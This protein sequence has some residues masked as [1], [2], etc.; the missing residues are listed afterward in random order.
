MHLHIFFISRQHTEPSRAA[1]HKKR[2]ACQRRHC[3]ARAALFA[4]AHLLSIH[5]ACCTAARLRHARCD[6]LSV[7]VLRYRSERS[8]RHLQQVLKRSLA[9]TRVSYSFKTGS[10]ISG[11][12]AGLHV[13]IH[14][15]T[16]QQTK[17][18]ANVLLHFILLNFS[19][20]QVISVVFFY[21]LQR[22]GERRAC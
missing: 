5:L 22:G 20:I 9:L 18:L 1:C 14:V 19:P 12:A 4:K 15:T 11:H 7:A 21:T 10:T 3:P 17:V 8:A 6:Y 16:F 2:Q 13:C